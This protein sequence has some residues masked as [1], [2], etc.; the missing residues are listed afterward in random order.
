[1]FIS[2]YYKSA[3]FVTLRNKALQFRPAGGC[4]HKYAVRHTAAIII[5]VIQFKNPFAIRLKTEL[6]KNNN[7][8]RRG[9]W[10]CIQ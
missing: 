4:N 1:M 9:Q 2:Y 3:V 7:R 5:P 6:R 8:S 10:I